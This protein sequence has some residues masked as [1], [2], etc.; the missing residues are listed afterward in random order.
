M[1]GT[2]CNIGQGKEPLSRSVRDLTFKASWKDI[3]AEP[4]VLD[5]HLA[6]GPNLGAG[7]HARQGPTKAAVWIQE[8]PSN[9]VGNFLR[10]QGVH[11]W[12]NLVPNALEQLV[13]QSP[14]ELG[15]LHQ[16]DGNCL[17]LHVEGC[18]PL[19]VVVSSLHDLVQPIRRLNFLTSARKLDK[20]E[21]DGT[22]TSPN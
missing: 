22:V 21:I 9:H 1:L 16:P 12:Q 20:L 8:K 10:L 2:A 14:A 17:P 3:L 13:L 5:L 11:L 4:L 19:V 18:E 7:D 6:K 15:R